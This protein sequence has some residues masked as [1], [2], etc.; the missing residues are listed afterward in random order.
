MTHND[1]DDRPE[2]VFGG[3]T[4]L[5]ADANGQPYVLLPIIP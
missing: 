2:A 3:T 4:T 1:A 5:H